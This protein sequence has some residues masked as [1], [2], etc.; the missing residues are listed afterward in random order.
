[1]CSPL[2]FVYDIIAIELVDFLNS[3]KLISKHQHGFLKRH[4][5]CTNLLESLNDWTLSLSNYKSVVV[6]YI[7][8]ARAF[9]SISHSKLITKLTSYGIRGNL[10]FW[11]QAFLTDRT[12]CV[13]VGSSFS[14]YRPVRSGV[15]QGSVLGPVLFNIFINDVTD[16]FDPDIKAKLFADD[17]KLYTQITTPSSVC[18]F[19]THLDHICSWSALWQLNISSTKCSLL[20]LGQRGFNHPFHLTS[21]NLNYNESNNDL[22][23]TIDQNLKFQQ[24]VNLITHRANQ[25]ANLIHRCFLSK[26]TYNL[27]RAFKTY[28]RPLLEYASPVWSHYTKNLVESIESVQRAFTKRIPGLLNFSYS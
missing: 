21:H 17:I 9:D 16:S 18:N 11:I 7:D 26:N 3:H 28:V 22:G 1:M 14:S 5:T 4:S 15:P 10:L 27:V 2:S 24:H 12:Q 13:L 23:I 6:A 19:Q 20:E 25:R 8:F